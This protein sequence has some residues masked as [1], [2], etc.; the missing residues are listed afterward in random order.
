MSKT[1]LAH[2]TL[3]YKWLVISNITS[4]PSPEDISLGM[5]MQEDMFEEFRSRNIC[6]T[7]LFEDDPQP[8]TDSGVE[9]SRNN[10][11]A[12]NLALRLANFF[13]KEAPQT[14]KTQAIQ[15]LSN[16]S[17][18]SSKTN[19]IQPPRR[20]ARGSGNTF[21]FSNWV[22]YYRA[23]PNA[24]IS[25]ATFKLKTD[26]IDFF[27]IDFNPYLLSGATIDSFELD[28][29][30][31]IEVLSSEESDGVI[32]LECKGLVFGFNTIKITV[33]T[34]TGRVNPEVVN[35]NITQ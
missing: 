32:T 2:V 12:T 5:E 11:V 1:K 14:L 13:G 27:S 15:S 35:F 33:T 31:G 6:S 30:D 29:S 17:A 28:I 4:E 19:Q 7:F 3:A 18:R 8:G 16:W 23:Q 34:S 10:A 22:R 25:C 24:P 20:Q 9:P 26:A 21:R